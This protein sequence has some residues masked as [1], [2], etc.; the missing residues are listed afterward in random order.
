MA[1]ALR[2]RSREA[3]IAGVASF[4]KGR[5]HGLGVD[6]LRTPN[7]TSRTES[8]L[9]STYTSAVVPLCGDFVA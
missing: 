4:W 5:R 9:A 7:D 1:V 3:A 8:A 6:L 2:S